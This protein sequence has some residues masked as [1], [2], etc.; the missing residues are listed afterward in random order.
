MC[1][2][3]LQQ[4]LEQQQQLMIDGGKQP[5]LPA[6]VQVAAAAATVEQQEQ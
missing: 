3:G 5:G 2:M 4:W 6:V 1:R